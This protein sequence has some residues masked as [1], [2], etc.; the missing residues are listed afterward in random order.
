VNNVARPFDV[1]LE[2]NAEKEVQVWA[3]TVVENTIA[4]AQGPV[5]LRV[6]AYFDSPVGQFR[7]IYTRT[8]NDPMRSGP[9][10]Q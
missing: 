1:E 2:P 9:A 10:T 5:T 3:P 4:G 6:T 7:Q 8:I